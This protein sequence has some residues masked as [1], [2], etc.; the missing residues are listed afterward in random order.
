[1]MVGL[2]NQCNL[3]SGL[4]SVLN[5]LSLP[6][7][8]FFRWV[9]E[10]IR[11]CAGLAGAVVADITVALL[12]GLVAVQG[13]MGEDAVAH[14]G[15]EGGLTDVRR[16]TGIGVHSYDGLDEVEGGGVEGGVGGGDGGTEGRVTGCILMV[17]LGLNA[18]AVFTD[19]LVGLLVARPGDALLDGV[20]G[21]AGAGCAS[22]AD[23]P[24]VVLSLLRGGLDG[25]G[26]CILAQADVSVHSVPVLLACDVGAL[27]VAGA[28]AGAV[29]AL[30]LR[31]LDLCLDE[32]GA[33]GC[34]GVGESVAS[35]VVRVVLQSLT[36]CCVIQSLVLQSDQR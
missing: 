17:V 32:E 10:V 5:A 24:E 11:L 25:A 7:T 12:R 9:S 36:V 31:C 20:E 14:R 1:M 15:A 22:V 27:A 34:E 19:L 28:E 29:N 33:G 4:G 6:R 18:W 26:G 8:A 2:T 13:G 3:L 23:A 21:S 16:A 30:S 35:V